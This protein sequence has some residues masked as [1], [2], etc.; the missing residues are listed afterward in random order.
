MSLEQTIR[1]MLKVEL[2]AHFEGSIRPETWQKLS[3][4]SQ[5]KIPNP[6]SYDHCLNRDR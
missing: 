3:R 6:R 2:H 1:L 4:C 5:V